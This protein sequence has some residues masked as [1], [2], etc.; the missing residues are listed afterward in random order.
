MLPC[1][2]CD[3]ATFSSLAA[4][5]ALPIWLSSNAL[6]NSATGTNLYAPV[7]SAQYCCKGSRRHSQEPHPGHDFNTRKHR[8]AYCSHIWFQYPRP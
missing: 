8:A 5:A 2:G 4:R 1:A 3:R 6:A 7:S